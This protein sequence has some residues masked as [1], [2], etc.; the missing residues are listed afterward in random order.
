MEAHEPPKIVEYEKPKVVDHGTLRELT[1]SGSLQNADIP[2]G[3]N[4]TAN[5]PS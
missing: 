1:L 4:G 5:P 3:I 2:M